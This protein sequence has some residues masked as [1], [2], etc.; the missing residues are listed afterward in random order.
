[1]G[2]PFAKLLERSPDDGER[3]FIDLQYLGNYSVRPGLCRLGS[4]I[5]FAN[6]DGG[7]RVTGVEYQGETIAPG[8]ARWD[9]AERI[10]L[11]GLM[12]HTTVW[13]QGM[14]YH[15]GGFAPVEIITH[16]MQPNHPIRR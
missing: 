10:A 2:G 12:T 6:G 8:D 15:V 1:M 4:K 14:E 13:R 11:A 5:H 16:N 9:F 3:Y 7:L